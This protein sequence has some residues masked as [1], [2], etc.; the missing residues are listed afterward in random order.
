MQ[1]SAMLGGYGSIS[2]TAL[3]AQIG[4]IATR[5]PCSIV[6]NTTTASNHLMLAQSFN[7]IANSPTA[8][9]GEVMI[10]TGKF[11]QYS[12]RLDSI[13]I[14]MFVQFQFNQAAQWLPLLACPIHSN[15]L[16]QAKTFLLLRLYVIS[17]LFIQIDPIIFHFAP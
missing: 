3:R 17:M 7:V 12:G 15:C 6:F 1:H 4:W 8:Y 11:S 14:C 9:I 5:K 10:R 16:L 2:S 13:I